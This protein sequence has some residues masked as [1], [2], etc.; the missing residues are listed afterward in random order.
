MYETVKKLAGEWY[1]QTNHA[2]EQDAR[3]AAIQ[4]WHDA[5]RDYSNN[6][7]SFGVRAPDGTIVT[8]DAWRDSMQEWESMT[9]EQQASER[10][11][12]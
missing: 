8:E 5:N 4:M 7:Y 11:N 6:P 9:H 2:T 3:A 10:R 12:T 1:P